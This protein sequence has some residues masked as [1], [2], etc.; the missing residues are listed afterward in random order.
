MNMTIKKTDAVEKV[1]MKDYESLIVE[2]IINV[3][4]YHAKSKSL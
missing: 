2:E 3:W 4:L 1:K